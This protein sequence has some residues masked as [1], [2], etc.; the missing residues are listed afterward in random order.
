MLRNTLKYI[1]I[2]AMLYSSYTAITCDINYVVLPMFILSIVA[3]YMT[4]EKE[5]ASASTTVYNN[6]YKY[7][8]YTSR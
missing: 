3:Y 5:V 8:A 1:S 2:V 4:R 7:R 6:R